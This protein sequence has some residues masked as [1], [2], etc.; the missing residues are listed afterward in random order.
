VPK[1]FTVTV[2]NSAT[3][4]VETSAGEFPEADWDRLIRFSGSAHRLA[5]C[6]LA[7]TH[8]QLRWSLSGGKNR[9]VQIDATFPPED[10]ILAFLHLMRPFLLKKEDTYFYDVTN[11]LSK[12]I[13]LPAFRDH[14]QALRQRF[15]GE[16]LAYHVQ[17]GTE[18]GVARLTSEEAV[19]RWLNAFEYH[20]F[21]DKRADLEAWY[22][23][24]PEVGA[25]AVFLTVL[26]QA[27]SAV[28]K[29]TVLIDGFAKPVESSGP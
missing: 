1:S 23:V 24:F 14:I 8:T 11:I 26:L 29:V 4:Q 16:H 13:T 19:Q 5:R 21:P 20:Q 12:H 7:E 3:G 2:S 15:A 27:A 22:R 6:R 9:S 18:R 25:R 10:D 28:G 17:V